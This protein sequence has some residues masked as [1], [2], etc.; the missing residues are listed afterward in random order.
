V[1]CSGTCGELEMSRTLRTVFRLKSFSGGNIPKL[2]RHLRSRGIDRTDLWLLSEIIWLR[3]LSC[4]FAT[5]PAIILFSVANG[6]Y[7]N[8]CKQSKNKLYTLN[9]C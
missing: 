4:A 3:K 2:S 9:C 5:C 1:L 6:F 7:G 8:F